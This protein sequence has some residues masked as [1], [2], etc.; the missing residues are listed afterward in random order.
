MDSKKILLGGLIIAI[1]L[2]ILA[3]FIA[4]PNPDGLES[5]PEKVINEKALEENLK[6]LGLEEEG[7]VAPSPMPDYTI[8]GLGK[9]G[10]ILAMIVGT[11]IVFALAYGLSLVLKK[12]PSNN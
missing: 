1:I 6:Q 7:T 11:I 8:P 12:S 2:S 9:I 4:S 5:T 3:P 10:E